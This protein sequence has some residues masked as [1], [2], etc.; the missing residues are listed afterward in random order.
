MHACM[1]VH[2]KS[3]SG[4]LGT[5]KYSLCPIIYCKTYNVCQQIKISKPKAIN[6]N[7]FNILKGC[8]SMNKIILVKYQKFPCVLFSCMHAAFIYIYFL[9]EYNKRSLT[10][11]GQIKHNISDEI[12]GLDYF[13][14]LVEYVIVELLEV[15]TQIKQPTYYKK[16][17]TNSHLH[18][19]GA[20]SHMQDEHISMLLHSVSVVWV[21]CPLYLR[22]V[23]LTVTGM[24]F[25]HH[26]HACSL[27]L[28]SFRQ[29]DRQR[30]CLTATLS[31]FNFTIRSEMQ[32]I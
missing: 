5:S 30:I 10:D 4:R 12:N 25:S 28:F 20:I 21:R 2:P 1:H 6:F 27:A 18:Q 17:S 32:Y 15:A 26:P 7:F 11:L 8:F 29:L 13:L 9:Q 31:L 16:S 14:L 3:Q 22:N 19:M 23:V 24:R